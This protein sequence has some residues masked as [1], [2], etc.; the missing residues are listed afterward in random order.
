MI[1][2]QYILL[3][4]FIIYTFIIYMV[5][6]TEGHFL[7]KS[8]IFRFVQNLKKMVLNHLYMDVDFC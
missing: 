8:I 6:T 1:Y 3:Y 5:F 7:K 2:I 4:I